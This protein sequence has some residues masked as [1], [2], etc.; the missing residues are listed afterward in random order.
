M[1]AHTETDILRTASNLKLGIRVNKAHGLMHSYFFGLDFFGG[2]LGICGFATVV[3][4]TSGRTFFFFMPERLSPI[5]VFPYLQ[6]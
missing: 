5:M 3:S 6:T 4:F 1:P 2:A